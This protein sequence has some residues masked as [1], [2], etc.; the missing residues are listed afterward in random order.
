MFKFCVD[1][2]KN[3]SSPNFA[4]YKGKIVII[5]AMNRI[6]KQTIGLLQHNEL[7]E[8]LH[9][10]TM[11]RFSVGLIKF[12]ML[13]IFVFDGKS[14]KKKLGAIIKRNT[15]KES[16][17]AKCNEID[18]KNS[19]EYFKNYKKSFSL[20]KEKIDECKKVLDLLGI[21]YINAPEE[22]D[23]QCACL[24]DYLKDKT[25][26]VIS[27]DLDILMYGAGTLLKSFTFPCNSE[28]GTPT[29]C[30]NSKKTIEI[31]KSKV[32]FDL[33]E[34]A[35]MI[36]KKANKEPL[37]EFTHENFVDFIILS[38][39]TDYDDNGNIVKI[40]NISNDELF[41]ICIFNKFNPNSIANVL[42]ERECIDSKDQ[43]LKSWD[44]IRK[45][46][47][48]PKVIDPKTI[49]YLPKE[50]NKEEIFNYLCNEKKMDTELVDTEL[51]K[52]N[53]NYEILKKMHSSKINDSFSR[54]CSYQFKQY[55]NVLKNKN[56]N[57]ITNKNIINN[58]IKD[59]SKCVEGIK[60]WRSSSPMSYE[61]ITMRFTRSLQ[62]RHA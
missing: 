25:V 47:L 58:K 12:G 39:T 37:E 16:M 6:Y 51:E 26:G 27:D 49:D 52:I 54:F 22:A 23:Q 60:C 62:W 21:C 15:Y 42:S 7:D 18:D 31:N 3:S 20:S 30:Q 38:G 44:S 36:L 43:F 57:K 55:T 11:F 33:H 29:P 24:S 41:E 46:Y 10:Q 40:N 17:R 32:L 9:I 34:K 53:L 14:P 2:I 56:K 4:N 50:I 61:P 19:S 59:T 45:V 5:D 48:S 1:Q 8:N 28:K 35:N 13:P